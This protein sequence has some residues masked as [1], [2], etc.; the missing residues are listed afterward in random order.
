M[1]DNN[2]G[3]DAGAYWQE[4]VGAG[5]DLAVVGHR[6][7]GPAYNGIIYERRVD[8]LQAMI[9]RHVDKPLEQVRVLDIGCG[10]GFYTS[11]WQA[12]GVRDYVGVDISERTIE[13]L[14]ELYPDYAFVHADVSEE[15]PDA[16]KTAGTFDVVT[17]FDVLYH[18]VDNDRVAA[19]IGIIA[20]LVADDGCLLVMDQLC[21]SEYQV[22]RHVRYRGRDSYLR[23]FAGNGLVLADSEL[24]FHY[25]VPPITSIKIVD[26]LFAAAFKVLG[27]LLRLSDR[28]AAWVATKL[29]RLD[30]R[31]R[32]RNVRVPNCELFAFSKGADPDV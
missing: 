22:S 4:R 28:L 19:A 16:L 26:F 13:H 8:A 15:L 5:A 24:L 6:A 3:F 2:N 23:T 7:M 32:A 9:E 12:H 21:Q 27:V 11:F 25:L 30:A 17:I 1:T 31:L 10:S 18:I 14:G 29:L 20:L